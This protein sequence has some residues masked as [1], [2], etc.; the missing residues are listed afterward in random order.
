[1][2]TDTPY[3][4]SPQSASAMATASLILGIIGIVGVLGGCCCC[5]SHALSLC[6]PVAAILG[7][8]ERQAIQ[9][10][11]SPQ[12]GAGMAQAGMILGMVGTGLMILYM[13]AI[14]VWII[15]AGF[16]SVMQTI[17]RGHWS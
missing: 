4:A 17:T 13:I 2:S 7:Y 9:E 10:G 1:M 5:I 12:A 8:R 3:A 6:A 14:I 15:V 11:R 16:T